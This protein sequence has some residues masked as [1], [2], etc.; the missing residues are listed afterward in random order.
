MHDDR[1]AFAHSSTSLSV[2]GVG[3]VEEISGQMNG[4][5]VDSNEFSAHAIARLEEFMGAIKDPHPAVIKDFNSKGWTAKRYMSAVLVNAGEDIPSC[6]VI[7]VAP[8]GTELHSKPEVLKYLTGSLGPRRGRPPNLEKT[9]ERANKR[10]EKMKRREERESLKLERQKF[11]ED[12]RGKEVL[13]TPKSKRYQR[14]RTGTA[15]PRTPDA[16]G[17]IDAVIYPSSLFQIES[18]RRELLRSGG[19]LDLIQDKVEEIIAD[20]RDREQKRAAEA[21]EPPLPQETEARP[22]VRHVPVSDFVSGFTIY[23]NFISQEE[24]DLCV[25]ACMRRLLEMDYTQCMR[26]RNAKGTGR[27]RTGDFR[28]EGFVPYSLRESA[29]VRAWHTAVSDEKILL[30]GGREGGSLYH[31]ER[32]PEIAKSLAARVRALPEGAPV[33]GSE[34]C[35]M[36]C[37][38]SDLQSPSLDYMQANFT[39]KFVDTT[40]PMMRELPAERKRVGKSTK[41]DGGEDSRRNAV[42]DWHRDLD[43]LGSIAVITLWG[44]CKLGLRRDASSK[45]IVFDIPPRSLYLLRP[46]DALAYEHCV[47]SSD[48]DRIS[49]IFR[50]MVTE[51]TERAPKDY[52]NTSS[53]E[54]LGDYIDETEMG[55]AITPQRFLSVGEEVLTDEEKRLAEGV[56]KRSRERMKNGGQAAELFPELGIAESLAPPQSITLQEDSVIDVSSPTVPVPKP[57]KKYKKGIVWVPVEVPVLNDLS[58]PRE[59]EVTG[60]GAR[61]RIQTSFEDCDT[62]V[63]KHKRRGRGG[64]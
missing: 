64:E 39:Q 18:A 20:Y 55:Q 5:V 27:A 29:G 46:P 58:T 22:N 31:V 41:A 38:V 34:E 54:D 24:E 1:R 60:R 48:M 23:D 3:G 30:S 62:S 10:L 16:R 17:K 56:A 52:D 19:W 61:R 51:P 50:T 15:R 14:E 13:R 40:E 28:Y 36:R 26:R 9:A 7:Y 6:A 12:N 43:S 57:S 47:L 25:D 37:S 8:D 53:D 2:T 42:L 21:D 11:K 44:S 63:R 59:E 4:A 32:M 33:Q 49:L 35:L 45:P